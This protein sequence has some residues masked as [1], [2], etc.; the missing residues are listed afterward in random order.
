ML[1][2]PTVDMSKQVTNE[3][4]EPVKK[5]VLSICFKCL[6][7]LPFH[8]PKKDRCDKWEEYKSSNGLM[9]GNQVK[10]TRHYKYLLENQLMR[11]EREAD[12]SGRP[13]LRFNLH[14]VIVVYPLCHA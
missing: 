4:S 5:V 1:S 3:Q 13:V 6:L 11:I 9:G 12:N 14:G 2:F 8:Q 10:R 7:D